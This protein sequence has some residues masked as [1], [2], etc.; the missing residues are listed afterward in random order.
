MS[1]TSERFHPVTD[2]KDAETCN[3]TLSSTWGI[4]GKNEKKDQSG[5]EGQVHHK[6][7]YKIN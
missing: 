5:Q 6:K 2:G 3:Q 7:T 4:L 1:L